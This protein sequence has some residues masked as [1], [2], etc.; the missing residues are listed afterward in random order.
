[1][2]GLIQAF[3]ISRQ[4]GWGLAG[5]GEKKRIERWRNVKMGRLGGWADG[6]MVDGWRGEG[7]G[8]ERNGW[9]AGKTG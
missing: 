1:M 8:E 6:W 9:V 2:A 4:F 5:L 3:V 7:R